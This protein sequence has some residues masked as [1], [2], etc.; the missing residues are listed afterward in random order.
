MVP[1]DVA[2]FL[3]GPNPHASLQFRTSVSFLPLCTGCNGHEGS[4]HPVDRVF[5]PSMAAS[6]HEHRAGGGHR[7]AARRPGRG[8]RRDRAGAARLHDP[9]RPRRRRDAHR[10]PRRAAADRR[11]AGLPQP[12]PAERRA[13]PQAP[14]RRGD[15]APPRRDR[16]RARR[17]AAARSHRTARARARRLP[18]PQPAAGLRPDD[19]VGPDRPVGAGPPATTSTTSRSRGR[20]S[21]WAR[22]RPGRTS[23][24]TWSATSAAGRRTSSSGC[25]PPCSRPGSRARG[26]WSTPRSSTAPLTST[27]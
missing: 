1:P 27:P 8:A 25:S 11:V 14:R 2:Q 4:E 3:P 18:G 16:R 22:T 5:R 13:R 21:D 23:R 7:A 15:G 24:P 12:R 19:R 20:S 10:P 9:G 26:R 6:P 17:G